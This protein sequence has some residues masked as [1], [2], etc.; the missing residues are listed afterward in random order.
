M[1]EYINLPGVVGTSRTRQGAIEDL[2]KNVK[3]HLEMSLF[4]GLDV[5]EELVEF[6]LNKK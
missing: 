1:A 6:F 4:L 5:P 3:P 2:L